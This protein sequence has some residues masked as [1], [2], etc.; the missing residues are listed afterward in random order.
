VSGR[1]I[2]V[3][4]WVTMAIFA[5][6]AVPDA[7]GVSAFDSAV[8]AVSLTLFLASLPVWAYAYFVGLARTARG[9]DVTVSSLFFLKPSAPPDVR[10]HLLGAFAACLVITVVT[11]AANPF[12]VLVPMLPLGLA[13]L[14]G[15]RYGTYP[16]R[17]AAPKPVRGGRR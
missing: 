14:W 4:S 3:T 11:A 6:V 1:W 13:G 12:A 5:I 8:V 17:K 10:R 2:V 9:D 7:L 16:P 15:A